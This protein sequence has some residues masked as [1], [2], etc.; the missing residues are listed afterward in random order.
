MCKGHLM[1]LMFSLGMVGCLLA[2]AAWAEVP[3]AGANAKPQTVVLL[4]GHSILEHRLPA[5]AQI[6]PGRYVAARVLEQACATPQ[7][8]ADALLAYFADLRLCIQTD[9]QDRLLLRQRVHELTGRWPSHDVLASLKEKP[10]TVFAPSPVTTGLARASCTCPQNHAPT[11]AV[12]C[13]AQTRTADAQI[14][15]VTFAAN[16]VDGDALSGAFSYQRDA[17]PVQSGLPGSLTSSCTN[18]AGSLQCTVNGSAPGPAGIVQLSLS[19]SDGSASLPLNSLLEVLAP[20]P[21]RIF[22]SGFEYLGC[23]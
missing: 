15:A 11:G 5:F 10:F 14:G 23:P 21:D 2:S 3:S 12:Q 20:V 8:K 13:T 9:D 17:N 4:S 22:A 18:A 19:V 16:D 1:R 7:L 6:E